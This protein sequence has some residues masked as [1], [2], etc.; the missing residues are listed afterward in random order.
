MSALGALVT[1][2][3]WGQLFAMDINNEVTEIADDSCPKPPE[4]ANGY[5]EHLVRYQC[6]PYYRL[7]T[8]GDGVYALNS[9]KQWVNKA[10]GEE[11][12]ECEA[13]CGKP[14]NPVDQ[15]QRI[16]GGSLDAKG[17]FPWQAKMI[18]RH[19]L[20][21]GA[22]LIS[23]QWLL[24]TAKNLFLNHTENATAEEI[25]PTLKLFVGKRQPVEI[26]K[27][28]FYPNYSI[29]DIGLIKLKQKVLV[30]ERVMPICLPLKDYAE[31]GRVGYVSGWGRNVNFRFTEHLKY[32]TLPV[33]NQ[34]KCVE[35]YEG[36]TVPEEKTWK[37]PVGV[38]P[39]LNEH[40]FC[41]GMSRY[42]EDTCYGDAGGA[43]A[44]HDLEQDTWY[45]A[46]ILSFDKSCTVAEYG[47]YVKVASILDWVQTTMANN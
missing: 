35:H 16:I 41:A 5:V 46:G 28:V 36:S 42:Q 10:I 27:V 19:N 45:A 17:S 40:T 32:V 26:E 2:L 39:I 38:Q 9:E 13:V 15:V 7:H 20:T 4:I 34:S 47:V 30:N 31:V 1:L 14:K 43:F 23:E 25:A 6:Q 29:V 12:P 33:A 18:S 37:S 8:E 21:T 11:L 44:I 22:T 3:L 24:T